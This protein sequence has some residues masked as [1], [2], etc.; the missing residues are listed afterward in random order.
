MIRTTEQKDAEST[1]EIYNHYVLNSHATF[2]LGS[3]ESSN[4]SFSTDYSLLSDSVG[5]DRTTLIECRDTTI[6]ATIIKAMLGHTNS[7]AVSVIR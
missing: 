5:L 2:E 7:H 3:I 6:M 4:L 1:V